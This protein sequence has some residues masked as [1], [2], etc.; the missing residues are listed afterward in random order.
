MKTILFTLCMAV[1]ILSYASD[2]PKAPAGGSFGTCSCNGGNRTIELNLN[3]D[4]TFKYIDNSDPAHARTING[5]WVM[6]SGKMLLTANDGNRS[7][8]RRWKYTADGKCIKSRY[9]M[10]WMRICVLSPCN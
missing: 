3:D 10:N 2:K 5:T 8:H 1:C 7:F 9:G 6:K 4:A